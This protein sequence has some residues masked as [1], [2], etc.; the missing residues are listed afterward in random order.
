[1]TTKDKDMEKETIMQ[2]ENLAVELNNQYRIAM[3]NGRREERKRIINICKIKLDKNDTKSYNCA[4]YEI[5]KELS[6]MSNIIKPYD[7]KR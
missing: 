7:N 3:E 6:D 2:V 4:L 5:I 1:M